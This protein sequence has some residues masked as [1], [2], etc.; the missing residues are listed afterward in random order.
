MHR[1]IAPKPVSTK[2]TPVKQPNPEP[3]RRDQNIINTERKIMN[4]KREINIRM[5]TVKADSV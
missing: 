5:E 3:L 1:Q 4:H 2:A